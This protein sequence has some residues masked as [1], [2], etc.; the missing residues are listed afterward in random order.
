MKTDTLLLDQKIELI[1]WL[2]S[3]EDKATIEKLVE[4]RKSASK[5]W[6]EA[7]QEEEKASIVKGVAD[8]DNNNLKPHSTARKLYE[9]WL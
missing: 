5:E 2:S 4:F 6:W 9:K 8:A 1:Q 3:L 7:I